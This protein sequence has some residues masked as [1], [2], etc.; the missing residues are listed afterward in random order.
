MLSHVRLCGHVRPHGL[1]PTRLLY[2]RDFPGKNGGVGCYFLLQ[3]TFST[4]GSDPHL[5]WQ[6]DSSP[7][8]HWGS[9]ESF[10]V[11]ILSV[12]IELCFLIVR[13]GFLSGFPGVVKNL[14]L[15]P[16]VGEDPLEEGLVT[17]PSTLA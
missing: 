7:L 16:G 15:R 5:Q 2:P 4:K 1:Q 6:V 13:V 14:Q 10:C 3:G 12:I 17:H 9:P 11:K 8:H